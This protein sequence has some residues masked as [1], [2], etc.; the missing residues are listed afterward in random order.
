MSIALSDQ[1]EADRPPIKFGRVVRRGPVP[2]ALPSPN[3]TSERLT[4]QSLLWE[5]LKLYRYSERWHGEHEA[6]A[7]WELVRALRSDDPRTRSIAAELLAK[8]EKIHLPVEAVRRAGCARKPGYKIRKE[9]EQVQE[10]NGQRRLQFAEFC[11][12]CG[13]KKKDWFCSLSENGL[14]VLESTRHPAS[15]PSD[16]ML[17]AEGQ[18]ARGAFVLCSG[19]VKLFTTSREGRVFIVRVAVAGEI[20]GLSAAMT[21]QNHTLTAET[22]GPCHVN[23]LARRDLIAAM[24]KNAEFGLRASIALSQE[25]QSMYRDIHD[26]VLG[27]SSEVKLARLLLSWTG[28]GKGTAQNPEIRIPSTMTHEEMAQMIG[29]SRETVTRLLSDLKKR[30]FIRVE[31]STL[32]IRDRTALEQLTA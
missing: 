9:G 13:L 30:E 17:F 31:G 27:P 3:F 32:V 8:T 26:F 2:I 12:D 25:F 24:E 16:S 11:R 28:R 21:G 5:P 7:G 10:S 15:Y 19:K 4:R 1:D 29:A 20:L 18:A 6:S 14:N 22:A 23:F